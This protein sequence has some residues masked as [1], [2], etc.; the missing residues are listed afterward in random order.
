MK[1]IFIMI[2]SCFVLMINGCS[3]E[4]DDKEIIKIHYYTISS[5]IP[6]ENDKLFDFENLTFSTRSTIQ[7]LDENREL[8]EGTVTNLEQYEKGY[9]VIKAFNQE[10]ANK[11]LKNIIKHGIYNL[12]ADYKP[13]S[14]ILDGSS[15]HLI[16]YFSD[17]STFNSKGYMKH[18]SEAIKINKDSNLLVGYDIFDIYKF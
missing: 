3:T 4:Y 5:F 6:F 12:K 16:I 14:Q 13:S 15:W 1:K 8:Y 18:P 9:E 17:G 11:F 7:D 2:V 10:E